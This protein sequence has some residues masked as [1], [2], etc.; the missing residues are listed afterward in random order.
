MVR[1]KQNN[2][3]KLPDDEESP[4]VKTE[5]ETPVNNNK[6]KS[7]VSSTPS[8][9]T[10]NNK[11][12]N[13]SPNNLKTPKTTL[14]KN[15][16]SISSKKAPKE[17]ETTTK[18]TTAKKSNGKSKK[19]EELEQSD[20]TESEPEEESELESGQEDV[21]NDLEYTKLQLGNQSSRR[22]ILCSM[23]E[24]PGYL[25]ECQGPCQ[26]SFHLDCLGLFAEPQGGNFKCPECV[27]S[28]HTCF[29]CKKRAQT[30]SDTKKCSSSVC[31]KYFHDECAKSN[32]LFRIETNSSGNNRI[33]FTCPSHTCLTCW[34]DAA[35][36]HGA[37]ETLSIQASKGRFVRCTRCPTSYHIGDHCLAAGSVVLNNS[38]IVCPKHFQPIKNQSH[39]NRVNV[40]WCFV[41][42]KTND[43]IGCNKCPAAYHTACLN[44]DQNTSDLPTTSNE[45][46]S[47]LISSTSNN[48]K[49]EPISPNGMSNDAASHSSPSHSPGSTHSSSSTMTS[50][51]SVQIASNWTCEDCLHGHRPLYGDIVWAKVGMYR[52]WPAQICVPRSLP[53]LIRNRQHQV[54]EFAVKFFGTND[55]YWVNIGRC[56]AFAEGDEGHK[57]SRSQK[58]LEV[59]FNKSVKQAKIAFKEVER[60]KASRFAKNTTNKFNFTFIKTNKPYGNV[61]INR[62]PLSE[63]PKCECDIKCATPCSSDSDCLNRMLK[64]E[65]HPAI[66]PAGERCQNQRFVKRLYPKQEQF[67]TGSRGWGLRAL[68]D[69][70][71]GDFVNE[72]VGEIIDDEECKRRLEDAHENSNFNF[73]FMTIQKNRIIDAGPKGNLARFANHS[74]DPNMETQKWLVNGDIRVGLFAKKDIPA[75]TELTFNYNFDCISN[76]K[77]ECKCGASNCSGFIGDRPKNATSS[78]SSSNTNLS[79]SASTTSLLDS[80]SSTKL[81]NGQINNEN[82]NGNGKKRKLSEI[83]SAVNKRSSLALTAANSLKQ[84]SKKLP[85]AAQQRARSLSLKETKILTEVNKTAQK[86]SDILAKNK[87]ANLEASKGKKNS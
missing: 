32:E 33:S 14:S 68:V 46:D 62:I 35:L 5:K 11:N 13:K 44:K 6:R 49:S 81:T 80:K 77:A 34:S 58:T 86:L 53:D 15:K 30:T 61:V 83:S 37:K 4:K 9:T 1:A 59:A 54:G 36:S 65:C 47:S 45:N 60:L 48:K 79:H 74:C 8:S 66:C 67:F 73:Y 22:E 19:S 52:W 55:Y 23:C 41:C 57:S 69:L 2:P 3:Q 42:C 78:G 29:L 40:S 84:S 24:L 51:K 39:H 43:L 18:T 63:L 16:K 27:S 26:S 76:E 28:L 50:V 72:Y 12:G 64:Y 21:I 38:S 70:K 10:L 82:S 85:V 20:E 56:F 7:L 25:L 31:G 87:V 71:K 75:C 17:K